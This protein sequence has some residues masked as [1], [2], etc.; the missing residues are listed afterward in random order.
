[1]D[2]RSFLGLLAVAPFAAMMAV[3]AEV[4]TKTSRNYVR[5]P[6]ATT[7]GEEGEYSPTVP[8]RFDLDVPYLAGDFDGRPARCGPLVNFLKC[9]NP[10]IIENR[11]GKPRQEAIC[12]E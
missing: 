3:A 11:V 7:R 5:I 8:Y 2:R 12:Q 4:R 9:K 6:F 10:S 1:M